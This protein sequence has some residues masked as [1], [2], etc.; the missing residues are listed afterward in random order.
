MSSELSYEHDD[1]D[2]GKQSFSTPKRKG[3]S[4]RAKPAMGRRRGKGPQS[5]NGIHK[6]RRRKM[7]W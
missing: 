4:E 7:S 3:V 1:Q 5:V 6:R 2:Y